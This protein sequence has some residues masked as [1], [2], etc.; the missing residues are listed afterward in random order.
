M[1]YS[2][3][4][5]TFNCTFLGFSVFLIRDILNGGLKAVRYARLLGVMFQVRRLTQ[6][7]LDKIIRSR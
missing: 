1:A 2:R 5:F 7:S 6:L 4:N 3:A